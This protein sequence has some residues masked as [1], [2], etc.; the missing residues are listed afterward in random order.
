MSSASKG[1]LHCL[2]AAPD[3]SVARRLLALVDAR[4]PV[5]LLGKAVVLAAKAH[6]EL[7]H[8]IASGVALYALE[9]DLQAYA[10]TDTLAG[11]TR[12]SYADWVSLSERYE[13]QTLWR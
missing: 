11:V 3:S 10:V 7:P 13:T 4:E 9:E 8:W 6:P 12:T 5:L 2:S 1:T